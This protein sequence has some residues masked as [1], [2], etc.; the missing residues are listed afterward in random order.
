MGLRLVPRVKWLLALTVPFT[1]IVTKPGRQASFFIPEL[2]GRASRWA[3]ACFSRQLSTICQRKTCVNGEQHALS[4]SY[5]LRSGLR[6]WCHV[7]AE[8]ARC[9]LSMLPTCSR[10]Q[11]E[12]LS[13]PVCCL[14]TV[15]PFPSCL[16]VLLPG[17]VPLW[18]YFPVSAVLLGS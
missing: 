14:P 18:N 12:P 4:Q 15:Y 17:F 6:A 1:V 3:A 11:C 7:S 13:A 8:G 5:D 9:G 2:M 16:V 10:L